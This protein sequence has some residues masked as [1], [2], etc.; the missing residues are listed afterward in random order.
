MKETITTEELKTKLDAVFLI[1]VRE[2]DEEGQIGEPLRMP[3]GQ[4]IRDCSTLAL[5]EKEI[6]CYC[7]GGVRGQIAVEFLKKK[8]INAKNL[9]GGY[10]AWLAS[11]DNKDA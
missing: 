7:Q 2:R 1:D 3:L 9:V 11:S 10:N 4:L 8:G 6:V 5:P